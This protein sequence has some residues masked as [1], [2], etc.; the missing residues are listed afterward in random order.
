MVSRAHTQQSVGPGTPRIRRTAARA[1]HARRRPR[2][3]ARGPTRRRRRAAAGGA[4]CSR[5]MASRAPARCPRRMAS[6]GRARRSRSAAGAPGDAARC[7]PPA[8][9]VR[10][11]RTGSS[12]CVARGSCRWCGGSGL[13]GGAC[14]ASVGCCLGGAAGCPRR[15]ASGGLARRRRGLS[16]GGPARWRLGSGLGGRMTPSQVCRS[17]G[18]CRTVCFTERCSSG[19]A[20]RRSRRSVTSAGRTAP[21]ARP[22]WSPARPSARPS[23]GPRRGACGCP[24]S[25]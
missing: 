2:S 18:R 15:A 12:R 11:A 23:R 13:G 1:S 10:G 14:A 16:L 3:A 22:P 19:P 4:G 5:R 24:A 21:A 6:R 20:G 17:G 8:G 7:R 25:P 9:G